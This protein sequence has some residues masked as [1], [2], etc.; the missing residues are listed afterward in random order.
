MKKK[1]LYLSSP[2]FADCDFPLIKALQQLGHDVTYMIMLAPYN[3][4]STLCDIKRQINVNDIIPALKYPELRV[5][6]KYMDMTKVFIANRTIKQDSS[7][8]S[9]RMTLKIVKFI[10]NGEFD[11][12]HTDVMLGMWNI[13]L[14]KLFGNKMV[15]TVHDPFPHSGEVSMRKSF[16]YKVAMN[17]AKKIV[18]LNNR[19]KDQFCT[20]YGIN[21]QRILINKLG[22][23]DNICNFYNGI[24]HVNSH[25]VLFFGRISP[26][27]GIE[28][29]CKAMIKVKEHIPDATLTIAGGGKMY[30]DIT[31]YEKM[32]WVKIINRYVGMEELAG[33]IGT[34]A[35]TVCP[36]TDATQS[37]V[38]MTSYS[39]CKPVVAT[40]VGGLGEMI[41]DGKTGIL[42]PPK[43]VDS[44][45][46]AIISLLA[47]ESL[48]SNMEKRIKEE[49]YTGDKSWK[50]IAD[51]YIEFYNTRL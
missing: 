32:E 4:R 29:L 22:I 44:L 48:R 51:K 25:D 31:P 16:N 27:K 6:E 15:L 37:G 38:I 23:Y 42:V 11:V 14:Y 34:C 3:L 5:Y 8:T 43:D 7:F 41:E 49:Y 40:N 46:D 26:Y 12:I 45:A 36:Y 50:V 24:K 19:Q 20:T 1:I 17:S 21:P 39:L 28:Y 30:F 10:R 13:M 33:L 18:L 9:L 2:S 35:L 47:N